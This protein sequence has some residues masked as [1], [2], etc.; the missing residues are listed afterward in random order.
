MSNQSKTNSCC[1]PTKQTFREIP[2]NHFPKGVEKCKEN[3]IDFLNESR[4]VMATGK[5]YHAY[6]SFEFALEEYG[7]IKMLKQSLV[8]TIGD[9]VLV[10]NKVFKSHENKC[11]EAISALGSE[12]EAIYDG[13]WEKGVWAPGVWYE[14]ETEVSHNTRLKCAFVDYLNNDWVIGVTLNRANLSH[15]IDELE[16]RTRLE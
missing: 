1:K 9:K 5:I 15:L 7:K 11:E 8:N 3:I 2:K 16:K 4:T 14:E 12:F 10:N 6:V 13:V